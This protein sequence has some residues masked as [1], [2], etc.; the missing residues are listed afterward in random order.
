MGRCAPSRPCHSKTGPGCLARRAL[1][2]KSPCGAPPK[3]IRLRRAKKCHALPG[4][5][6]GLL[7]GR[8]LEARWK[9]ERRDANGFAEHSFCRETQPAKRRLLLS[10]PAAHVRHEH[11]EKKEHKERTRS[12]TR[13]EKHGEQHEKGEARGAAREAARAQARA[14]ARESRAQAQMAPVSLFVPCQ[15]IKPGFSVKQRSVILSCCVSGYMLFTW[16]C[17]SPSPPFIEAAKSQKAPEAATKG[18]TAT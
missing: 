16:C 7:P 8:Q 11:E 14:Q 6:V 2:K 4:M 9:R 17:F 15:G 18:A 12:S 13:S 3:K 5:P 1:G 10:S